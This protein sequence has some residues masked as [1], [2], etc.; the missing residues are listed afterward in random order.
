MSPTGFH[1]V[2]FNEYLT[3]LSSTLNCKPSKV[4]ETWDVRAM[5]VGI[6]SSFNAM[7]F[8]LIVK[9]PSKVSV[10]EARLL[11][12][13]ASALSATVVL[14]L[15]KSDDNLSVFATNPF[16]ASLTVAFKVVTSVEISSGI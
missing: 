7:L 2:L 15:S 5:D 9:A 8:P 1:V 14:K 6:L 3:L 12:S 10:R 11:T 4:D 16:V 13:S